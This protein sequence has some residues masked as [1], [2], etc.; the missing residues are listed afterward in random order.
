MGS[1][2][3]EQTTDLIGRGGIIQTAQ[4]RASN[5]TYFILFFCQWLL[6]LGAVGSSNYW[7]RPLALL[8]I[9]PYRALYVVVVP[10]PAELSQ[11][12]GLRT[13]FAALWALTRHSSTPSD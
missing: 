9:V 7:W 13:T 2:R 3:K 8:M 4:C 6:L 1:R 10:R 12:F 5:G 11:G